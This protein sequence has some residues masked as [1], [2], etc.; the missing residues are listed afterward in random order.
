MDTGN[1]YF[2][3]LENLKE[4]FNNLKQKHP[5]HGG[6]FKVGEKIELKGSIFKI[7][8]IKPTELRLKLLKR[9]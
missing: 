6:I 4:E 7:K 3:K 1:G 8:S 2:E 5:N 9:P